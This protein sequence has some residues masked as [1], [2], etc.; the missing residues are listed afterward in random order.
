MPMH[1]RLGPPATTLEN[2]VFPNTPT[3]PPKIER[4]IELILSSFLRSPSR[5]RYQGTVPK[6]A[7]KLSFHENGHRIQKNDST[8]RLNST[9]IICQY[10]GPI[11][12]PCLRPCFISLSCDAM[13]N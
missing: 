1:A 9:C 13:H 8:I 5:V 12:P 7:E 6:T 3:Q 4:V 11:G 10:I 2:A